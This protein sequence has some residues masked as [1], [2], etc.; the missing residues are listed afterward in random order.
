MSHEL[1][2]P[3]ELSQILGVSRSLTY[4]LLQHGE[5][6]SIKIG[7]CVRVRVED[8]EAFLEQQTKRQQPVGKN[9]RSS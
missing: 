9:S 6:R 3:I 4:K 1:L 5:I 2:K 7:K 8:L